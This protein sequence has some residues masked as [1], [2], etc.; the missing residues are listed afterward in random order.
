MARY[1]EVPAG[2]PLL[3]EFKAK[4]EGIYSFYGSP[5]QVDRPAP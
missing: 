2:K 3:A 4:K 1:G 5:Y